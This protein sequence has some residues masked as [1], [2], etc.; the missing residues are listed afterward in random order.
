MTE[1]IK[2]IKGFEG[3]YTISN[4]GIVRSL[5]TNKV[6]K[7]SITKYGYARVLLRL[8]KSRDYKTFFV[9]R[10]V[11]MNFIPNPNDYPE[12]NHRDSNRLN[13]TVT[14]LEWCTREMNVKHSFEFGKASNKGYRNPNSKLNIDD[15]NAIKAIHKTKRFSNV[16]IAKYFRVSPSTIDCI[17]QGKTWGDNKT[18]MDNQQLSLDVNQEK[19]ND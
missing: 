18:N 5:L 17:I 9:H 12:V 8:P 1:V 4:L 11:A 7:P 10:L 3:R 16:K 2:D 19:F 14:N 13:N 6:M 15:V